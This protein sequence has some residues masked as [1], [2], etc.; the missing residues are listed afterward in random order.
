VEGLSW[1][2]LAAKASQLVRELGGSRREGTTSEVL[3]LHRYFGE[4]VLPRQVNGYVIRKHG[5]HVEDNQEWPGDTTPG[6]YLECLR[7]VVLDWRSSIFLEYSAE[8]D[9]WTLYVVGRVRRPWRG[10][11]SGG[12]VVVIFNADRS[13]WVTGF[14]PERGVEYVNSRNGFWLRQVR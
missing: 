12:S 8:E 10:P 5:T 13:L 9:D 7:T 6:A 1:A 14:Q 11:S 2:E 4:H 3:W